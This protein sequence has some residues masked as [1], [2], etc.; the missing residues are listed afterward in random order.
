MVF[1]K[2]LHLNLIGY[3][4]AWNAAKR[5][6]ESINLE[7]YQAEAI[8]FVGP[9]ISHSKSSRAFFKIDYEIG[10]LSKTGTS[11]SIARGHTSRQWL[12]KL[13]AENIE[14]DVWNLHWMPGHI[15]S[16]FL[17]F[18][19][20]KSVVWTLHDMNPFTGACHYSGTCKEYLKDC[21]NCPQVPRLLHPV[22]RRLLQNKIVSIRQIENLTIVSP[23]KWLY[24]AFKESSLGEDIDIRHI[25]NPVP[26]MMLNDGGKRSIPTVTI[27]GS[28]YSNSKNSLI[29]ARAICKFVEDFPSYRFN[30]QVIGLPFADILKDQKCLPIGSS[31]NETNHFLEQS[32]VFIYTSILDNLPSFV[33]EA[34]AAG[35]VVIAFN[36][37]GISDCLIPDISG[38]LVEENEVGI[39]RALAKVL[40]NQ[41][42]M[43]KMATKGREYIG[44][45]FSPHKIGSSYI[46][47]YKEIC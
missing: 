27:L 40:A 24:K 31:E 11:I 18:F 43:E 44:E 2:S 47:L 1:N 26:S 34:Q 20:N 16:E 45:N 46:S 29:G 12:S 9:G 32:D 21:D 37:G 41:G 42:I 7:G 4:G 3:G 14:A 6:A 5:I 23:S 39:S 33:L 8:N 35:N 17:D 30:L 36:K 38:F 25:P 10:K 22:V 19:R 13:K 15:D 28:N